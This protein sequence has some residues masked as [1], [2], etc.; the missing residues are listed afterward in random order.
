M[1]ELLPNFINFEM[2]L[3][4]AYSF[5]S[6]MSSRG[7]GALVINY[8]VIIL[9]PS[10][11]I[12]YNLFYLILTWLHQASFGWCLFLLASF[13]FQPLCVPIC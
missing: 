6:V 8:E 9:G 7:A 5:R 10:H 13:D 3:L 1:H 11:V 2:M 12:P 4:G